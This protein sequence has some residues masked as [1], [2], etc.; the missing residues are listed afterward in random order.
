MT[1]ALRAQIKL[2]RTL[3]YLAISSR[4]DKIMDDYKETNKSLQSALRNPEITYF[5]N[6]LDFHINDMGKSWKILR[7]ILG[8]DQNKRKKQHRFFSNKTVYMIFHRTRIKHMSGV[9]NS[10]VMDKTILVKT[11]SLKYFDVIVDH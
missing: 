3:H 11:S 10:I 5:S 1:G 2:K 9:A 4:D 6:Q 8:N 7:T